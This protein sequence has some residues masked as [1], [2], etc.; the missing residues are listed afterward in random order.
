M[1]M[2]GWEDKLGNSICKLNIGYILTMKE[3]IIVYKLSI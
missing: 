1:D 3:V 2:N